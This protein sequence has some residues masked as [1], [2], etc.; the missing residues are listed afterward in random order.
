MQLEP[1]LST[2][3]LS[4]STALLRLLPKAFAHSRVTAISY[5]SPSHHMLAHPSLAL[6]RCAGGR[7]DSYREQRPSRRSDVD[8]NLA[9]ERRDLSSVVYEY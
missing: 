2:S 6:D 8:L 5:V 9:V 4:L 3:T 7:L 1:P